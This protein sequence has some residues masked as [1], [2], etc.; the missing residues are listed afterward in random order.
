MNYIY[1]DVICEIFSFLSAREILICRLICKRFRII[2]DTRSI[3]WKSIL[4]LSLPSI[5]SLKLIYR[6]AKFLEELQKIGG[7]VPERVQTLDGK[8]GKQEECPPLAK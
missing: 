3:I 7:V 1:S 4:F 6:V 2:I 8:R 5:S